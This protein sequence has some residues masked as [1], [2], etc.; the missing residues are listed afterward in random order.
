M[1]L[2]LKCINNK[3]VKKKKQSTPVK[4]SPSKWGRFS[5]FIN[6]IISPKSGGNI[7]YNTKH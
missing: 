7:Y 1:C 5:D 2:Y 6:S 3:T 4:K